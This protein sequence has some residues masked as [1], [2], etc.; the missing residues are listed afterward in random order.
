MLN[1]NGNNSNTDGNNEIKANPLKK[2]L[3]IKKDNKKISRAKTVKKRNTEKMLFVNNLV[4]DIDGQ[5]KTD[6][7]FT[8]EP[9]D[10][11]QDK[12]HKRRK[13]KKNQY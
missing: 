8:N 4:S 12:K 2:T 5:V 10:E 6:N 3:T 11:N 1:D 9:K 13:S 7:S